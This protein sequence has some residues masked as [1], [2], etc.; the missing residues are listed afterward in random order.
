MPWRRTS[1]GSRPNRG[2][3]GLHLNTREMAKIGFLYLNGGRW[4]GQQVSGGFRGLQITA[5]G[6]QRHGVGDGVGCTA[7][8]VEARQ[9][10]LV[11]FVRHKAREV[12]VAALGDAEQDGLGEE[13]ALIVK[14]YP[15]LR[16]EPGAAP[17]KPELAVSSTPSRPPERLFGLLP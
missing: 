17:L 13:R 1:S 2:G 7:G 6:E 14:L 4:D 3:G 15:R 16:R 8:D 11:A 9:P 12:D 5:I 10:D